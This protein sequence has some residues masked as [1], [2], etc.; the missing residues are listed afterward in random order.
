MSSRIVNIYLESC[1]FQRK[2]TF[3]L[4]NIGSKQ[5]KIDERNQKN[6]FFRPFLPLDSLTKNSWSEDFW[7][8]SQLFTSSAHFSGFRAKYFQIFEP[9]EQING[10][11]HCASWLILTLSF[12]GPIVHWW[13]FCGSI[14][15]TAL[16]CIS[17]FSG[18]V[19]IF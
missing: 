11:N 5:D 12:N 13:I 1:R 2:H 8:R 14:F 9:L 17:T 15:K 19:F 7:Q 3:S 4:S 18:L 16:W 10:K 6:T